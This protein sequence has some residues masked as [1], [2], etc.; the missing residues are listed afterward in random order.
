MIIW[1]T[2]CL[3]L[4]RVLCSTIIDS[5]LFVATFPGLPHFY[6]LVYIQSNTWRYN[7]IVNANQRIK[8]GAGLATR[9]EL[10]HLLKHPTIVKYVGL[11]SLHCLFYCPYTLVQRSVAGIEWI[12]VHRKNQYRVGHMGKVHIILCWRFPHQVILMVIILHIIFCGFL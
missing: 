4:I 11:F 6:S 5:H 3:K 10:E 8:N 2:Y 1:Q 7:I 12:A 9:L